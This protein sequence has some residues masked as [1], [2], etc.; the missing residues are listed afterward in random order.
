MDPAP[1]GTG[2]P[3]P[4]DLRLSIDS[5]APLHGW[6]GTDR[7]QREFHGWTGLSATLGELAQRA[8]P[9]EETARGGAH[10]N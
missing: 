8:A 1:T 6:L 10:S 4:L 9:S 5:W 7:D 2:S 3:K